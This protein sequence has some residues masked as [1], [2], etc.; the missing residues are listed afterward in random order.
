MPDATCLKNAAE[1]SDLALNPPRRLLISRAVNR[2]ELGSG[3]LLTSDGCSRNV[4][5]VVAFSEGLHPQ[6]T[7]QNK[8]LALIETVRM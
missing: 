6:S 5:V 2:S 8:Y 4:Q 3:D 7:A 1:P